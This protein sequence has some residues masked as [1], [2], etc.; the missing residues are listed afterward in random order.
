MKRS[1]FYVETKPRQTVVEGLRR[2]FLQ[3]EGYS[4]N[5]RGRGDEQEHRLNPQQQ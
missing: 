1:T 3:I 4:R 2:E 5:Y